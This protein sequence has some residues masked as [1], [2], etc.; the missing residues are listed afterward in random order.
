ME[1]PHEPRHP[2]LGG[3]ARQRARG[4]H[5]AGDPGTAFNC[6]LQAADGSKFSV[7]GMT[8]DYPAG[9]DPNGMK[10]VAVNSSHPE[11]FLGRAGISPGEASDWFREFQVSS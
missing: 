9:S 8:P 10:F 2:P 11:A 4:R 7:S 5:S 6:N 3:A 1:R